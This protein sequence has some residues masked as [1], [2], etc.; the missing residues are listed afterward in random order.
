MDDL[1]LALELLLKKILNNTKSLENQIKPL[2]DYFKGKSGS[3]ELQNMFV[4]LVDYYSKYQNT[5]VKHDDNV[6]EKEI[7]FIIELTSSLMK[8]ILKIK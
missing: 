2:G 7:D 5:Y 3:K 6:N 8:F 4:K 1:R